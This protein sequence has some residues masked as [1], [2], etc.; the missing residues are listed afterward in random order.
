VRINEGL[1]RWLQR[2]LLAVVVVAIAL[3]VGDWA[4]YRLRG[5][6]SSTVTVNSYQTV[7]LKGNKVEYDYLGT[8]DVPCSISLFPQGGLSPCW[9]LR[10]NPNQTV[11]L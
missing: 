11:N 7:P 1:K 6:P 8:A 4:V 2:V 10:R 5:E 3:Y 9:R